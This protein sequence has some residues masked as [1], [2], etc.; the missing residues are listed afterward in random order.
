MPQNAAGWRIEPPVSVPSAH[1]AR[2]P[3][4]AAAEP[5]DEPPGTQ[6]QVP[7]VAGQLVGGVLGRGAHRELVHVQSCRARRGPPSCTRLD[8][9]GVDDRQ[10]ALEDARAGRRR[11]AARREQVLEPIGTPCHAAAA[12]RV[13]LAGARQRAVGVGV[14][15]GAGLVVGRDPVEVGLRPARRRRSRARRAAPPR[16]RPSARGSRWRPSQAPI[17][18]TRK[19][20]WAGSGAFRSASACDTDG[21]GTSSASTFTRSS[22]CEVD[23]HARQVERGDRRDVR[24]DG[25]ELRAQRR[26]LVVVRGRAARA[27]R[28]AGRRNRSAP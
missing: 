10:E 27:A 22:G 13:E 8:D 20:S 17:G 11:H 3:A 28:R 14:Q 15:E 2:P 12:G 6:R 26:D 4:T 24:E 5:P 16:A 9:V 21:T 19:P 7:R 23:R 18:G 1:G 25:L